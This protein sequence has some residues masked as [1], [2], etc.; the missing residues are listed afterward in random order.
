VALVHVPARRLDAERLQ[1]ARAAR[2]Q[3]QLLL[4]AHAAVA[5]VE[6]VGDVAVGLAVFLEVGVEEVQRHMAHLGAP[7]LDLERTVGQRE[8]DAQLAPSA[9]APAP[10]A[11]ARSRCRRVAR[12]LTA[13]GVDRLLEVALAVEQPHADEGQAQVARGLA[14]VAREDA[15]APGID[16]Q[17]LVQAELGAEVGDRRFGVK[18]RSGARGAW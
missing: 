18:A 7:D 3:H 5:L 1:R 8:P 13:V 12:L 9:R 11:A 15:Q 16:R 4:E 10:P 6:P 14:V 2:A 17:A